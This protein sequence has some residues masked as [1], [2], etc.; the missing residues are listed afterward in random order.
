M[1]R[2]RI[3]ICLAHFH[4]IVGGSERRMQQLAERWSAWGHEVFVLTRAGRGL[5]PHEALGKVQIHR[6]IRTL[7]F[8]P[9]FGATY[10]GSLSAQLALRRRQYDVVVAG[11]LPWDAVATG[12]AARRLGKAAIAFAASTGPAGDV[13]QLLRAKGSRLLCRLV[14][15]N[16]RLI[17][18]SSQARQEL[19]DLGCQPEQVVHSTNGVDL[20]HYQPVAD[21]APHRGRTVLFLS[22]LTPAKNPQL[23]LRAWKAV[24]GDGRYRLIVAGDGPLAGELHRLAA[25]LSLVNV[26]FP[27]NVGD[28]P[29]IHRHA[30]VFVLPSPSEGCSNALLEAMASGLCPV[31]SRVPGNLDVVA[32]GV[33]GLLFDHASERELAEALCRVLADQSL[34]RRLSAAARQHVVAHHDLNQIAAELIDLVG[35]IC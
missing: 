25:E 27:G 29:A 3:A 30:S 18:I 15:S 17:A 24:N 2:L 33:S 14:R 21:E 22:R 10:I 16:P 31:V 20:D 28:V 5:P 4:P 11:Q 26:E 32:D 9:A 34:R 19:L 35:Q 7:E 13:Q 1:R 23:L 12:F 6:V 8:G